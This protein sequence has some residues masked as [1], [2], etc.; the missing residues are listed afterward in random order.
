MCSATTPPFQSAIGSGPQQDA[1]AKRNHVRRRWTAILEE[2]GPRPGKQPGR[3]PG[4]KLA[5]TWAG[6]WEWRPTRRKF[7]LPIKMTLSGVVRLPLFNSE[8]S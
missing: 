2:K 6:N 3:E 8:K 5:R 4:K 1:P 7:S